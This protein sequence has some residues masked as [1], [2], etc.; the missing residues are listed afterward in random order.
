MGETD[1]IAI[2]VTTL[3]EGITNLELGIRR[4][5]SIG[6]DHVLGPTSFRLG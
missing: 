3:G 2:G 5:G 4:L 6:M 1:D